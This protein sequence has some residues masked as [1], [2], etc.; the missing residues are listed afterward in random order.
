MHVASQEG[1]ANSSAQGILLESLDEQIA[2]SLRRVY[3]L[4]TVVHAKN[5]HHFEFRRPMVIL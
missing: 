5:E 2:L 1:D 4:K 3:E